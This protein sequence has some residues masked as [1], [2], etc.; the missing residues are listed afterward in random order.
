MDQTIK[1]ILSQDQDKIVFLNAPTGSG[2]TL[3]MLRV[4]KEE[5]LT[6]TVNFILP[7]NSSMTFLKNYC[8]NRGWTFSNVFM[9]TPTGMIQECLKIH[10]KKNGILIMDECHVDNEEYQF[11]WRYLQKYS[12]TYSKIIFMSA[13]GC[14]NK[15]QQ[16]FP[17]IRIFTVDETITSFRVDIEY[18]ETNIVQYYNSP[19]NQQHILR[20]LFKQYVNKNQDYRI[21]VFCW[22]S[23]QCDTLT[24]LFENEFDNCHSYYGKQDDQIKINMMSLFND[25]EQNFL[26]FC[27]NALE[28][29]VTIKDVNYIFDFGKQFVYSNKVLKL[30]WCDQSSMIQRAGR[31]GRTCNGRVI[32]L[33]SKDFYNSL[34]FLEENHY[35]FESILL[36]MYKKKKMELAQYIFSNNDICQQFQERLSQ[37][38]IHENKSLKFDFVYR[39]RYDMNMENALLLFKLYKRRFMY[40]YNELFFLYLTTAL[41]ISMD[42]SNFPLFYIPKEKRRNDKKRK[43]FK[44]I[45]KRFDPNSY[46]DELR[47]YL[48]IILNA[49]IHGKSFIQSNHLNNKCIQDV[50]KRFLRY[51]NDSITHC[52]I[53]NMEHFL[54][55]HLN[56]KKDLCDMSFM[57]NYE[58]ENVHKFLLYHSHFERQPCVL[59][60]AQGLEYEHHNAIH[61]LVPWIRSEFV[62]II[63]LNIVNIQHDIESDIIDH[64]LVLW[65][66]VPHDVKKRYASELE[67]YSKLNEDRSMWKMEFQNCVEEIEEEVAY[68]PGKYKMLEARDAFY[69]RIS[70]ANC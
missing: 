11:I 53:E 48:N 42:V 65:T 14:M 47:T 33:M 8:E 63:K 18:M 20:N 40:T 32:R 51:W 45:R 12:N 9:R 10:S 28:T 27:T 60:H 19:V 36:T 55:S 57:Y 15:I 17:N 62:W 66:R 21:L 43:F 7:T 2:K 16:Y 35:D 37:L 30:K 46:H 69:E 50:R 59:D 25:S 58:M 31:T 41:L 13:T 39:Y 23:T 24:D 49:L 54:V 4:L 67:Y 56:I 26:I 64:K 6:D 38:N 70:S 44:D 61:E 34:P 3:G 5:K 1:T 68:R 22:S 52:R 29:S